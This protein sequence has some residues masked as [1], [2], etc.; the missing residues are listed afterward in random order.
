MTTLHW[1]A[2]VIGSYGLFDMAAQRIHGGFFSRDVRDKTFFPVVF[3]FILALIA[4]PME[5]NFKGSPDNLFLLIN[6]L[7]LIL[8][9]IF[10]R[11]K[12][13]LEL[14][15]GFSMKIEKKVDQQLVTTGLN[16]VIRHPSYLA[17]ILLI[18]GVNI[19]LGT[20]YSWVI[21]VFLI[22]SLLRRIRQEEAF[23]GRNLPGYDNYKKKTKR[24]IPFIY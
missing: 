14:K 1:Y 2:V 23:L 7:L 18:T 13:V 8:F 12:A 15:N 17:I 4:A 3:F 24:I 5:Y 6:G 21:L 19:M 22:L 9:A 10:I 11:L 20:V 16:S